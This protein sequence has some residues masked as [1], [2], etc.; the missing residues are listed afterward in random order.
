MKATLIT[1]AAFMTSSALAAERVTFD[2]E[3]PGQSPPGWSAG[4]TGKG[5]FK[6]I[7]EKDPTAPS[8][9]HSLK[10]SA[11]GDFP[12]I[13]K[14]NSSLENG[15]VEVK[16]KPISGEEDQAGGIVWRFKDGDHYYVT[17]ANALEN[18]VSLYYTVKGK[19]K[20]IKYTDEFLEGEDQDIKIPANQWHTLRVEF[21][22]KR[23]QVFLNARKAIDLE[24]DEIS[25]A[26]KV[27]LW[28]KADSVTFFDD[29]A[30]GESESSPKGQTTPGGKGK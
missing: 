12:W 7:I 19:R 13:V 22:G 28:T 21:Q 3:K 2:R 16:F 11:T 10:Q 15:F 25:G 26:G 9:S 6:W 4:V 8:Q 20:T 30:Y 5:E 14:E 1:L 29:F 17:R 27:G 24:D 23:I 18:N